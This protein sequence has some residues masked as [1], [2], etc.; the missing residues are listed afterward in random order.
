[1]FL[2]VFFLGQ[3]QQLTKST[4]EN[5]NKCFRCGRIYKYKKGLTQHLTYECGID[6]Q[7]QCML[8]S[9]KA[10]R[11]DTLKTHIFLRHGDSLVKQ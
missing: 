11:P 4:Q 8:C 10:S 7:Y 3:H 9:Y 6:P 1:M 2:N 5:T